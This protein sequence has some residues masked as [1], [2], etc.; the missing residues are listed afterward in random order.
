VENS[1]LKEK[2]HMDQFMTFLHEIS[3]SLTA[4]ILFYLF[5]VIGTATYPKMHDNFISGIKAIGGDPLGANIIS[6][7][8]CLPT[9]IIVA[10]YG[11]KICWNNSTDFSFLLINICIWLFAIWCVICTYFGDD[12]RKF[13]EG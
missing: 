6:L 2:I 13:I 4:G 5:G 7:L 9:I 10:I 3:H 11:W 8:F 12:V 1:L